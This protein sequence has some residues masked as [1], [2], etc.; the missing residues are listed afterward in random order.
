V[1]ASA[2]EVRLP[3][4][5][6][7]RPVSPPA[8][9]WGMVLLVATESALFACLIAS[10]FYLRFTSPPG[11]PPDGIADP[12]LIPPLRSTLVLLASVVPIHVAYAMSRRGSVVMT[13]WALLVG[14]LL[15]GAYLALQ[16]DQYDTSLKAFYPQ[17][18]AYASLFYTLSGTLA[19]HVAGGMLLAG[20]VLLKTLAPGTPFGEKRDL[21]AR[22][23]AL[24]WDFLGVVAVVL[25][26]TLY[27][28]PR[29]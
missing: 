14:F 24:Y 25:Y 13:R 23:T 11:W 19:A 17:K 8:G 27:L 4:R 21:A 3:R 18:N 5:P 2:Q 15:A 6:P 9:W 29:I 10:Y 22:V 7:L 16:V 28:S 12:A 20:W 26:L 1:T